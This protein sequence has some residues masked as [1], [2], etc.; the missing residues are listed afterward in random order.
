MAHTAHSLYFNFHN[1]LIK[2]YTGNP[3]VIP[4]ISFCSFSDGVLHFCHGFLF[5]ENISFHKTKWI[6]SEGGWGSAQSS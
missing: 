2:K 1:L 6:Q 4:K 3:S 5:R